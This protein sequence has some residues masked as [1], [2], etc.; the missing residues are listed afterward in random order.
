MAIRIAVID[1]GVS[2][3]TFSDLKFCVEIDEKLKACSCKKA[4]P[5]DSHGTHCAMIIKRY[6]PSAQIG[7]I[8][9]LD[10]QT[11]SGFVEKLIPALDWC[12]NNSVSLINLSLGTTHAKDYMVIKNAI[13]EYKDHMVIVAAVCNKNAVSYPA[14]IP[15]VIGVCCHIELHDDEYF[16]NPSPDFVGIDFYASARHHIGFQTLASNSFAAPLI[17]AKVSEIMDMSGSR[18]AKR[19]RRELCAQSRCSPFTL[20]EG[21]EDGSEIP[22]IVILTKNKIEISVDVAKLF[23]QHEYNALYLSSKSCSA[24]IPVFPLSDGKLDELTIEYFLKR[25]ETDVMI[26]GLCTEDI[27]EN[28]LYFDCDLLFCGMETT[29][30]DTLVRYE[31]K[32]MI[33]E[34]KNDVASEIYRMAFDFL[35]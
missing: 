29:N 7:S 20:P 22:R 9:I 34:R 21:R 1:D 28:S 33:D 12:K 15:E 8:K 14:S 10:A 11:G 4:A 3:E 13:E 27:N 17:T 31:K 35:I 24:Q 5:Q 2:T 23:I 26:M 25:V 30:L 6:A 32:I 18:N 16:T 19:I